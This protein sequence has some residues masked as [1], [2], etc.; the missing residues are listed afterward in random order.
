LIRLVWQRA[1]G[2]CE[3]YQ[4]SQEWD[5]GPF[6]IDHIISREHQGPTVVGNLALSCFRCSFLITAG[7]GTQQE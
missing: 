1:N 6:E 2:C 3:Y 7:G 4:L 5:D